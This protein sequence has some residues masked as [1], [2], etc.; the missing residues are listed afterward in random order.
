MALAVAAGARCALAHPHTL[1]ED[2]VRDLI[3]AH[4]DAGLSGLEAWYGR[5]G[6]D[7]R[8]R[9]ADLADAHGLVVTGGSDFHGD[10]VPEVPTL[11]VDLPPAR[12]QALLDW[13]TPVLS[14]A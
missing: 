9:W 10:L 2:H 13:L 8:R 14:A 5:Y 7:E 3:A 6:A 4:R 11:G 1:G 12:A